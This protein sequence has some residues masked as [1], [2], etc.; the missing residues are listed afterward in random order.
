MARAQASVG[1]GVVA[2]Q[3]GERIVVGEEGGQTR[4]FRL[5]AKVGRSPDASGKVRDERG[6]AER[7][8][9]EP[10]GESGFL[11]LLCED[12]MK[13]YEAGVDRG[14]ELKDKER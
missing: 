2:P 3:D 5:G 9:L 11:R 4:P 1:D 8:E 10:F 12:D 6:E 14:G 13:F 7:E